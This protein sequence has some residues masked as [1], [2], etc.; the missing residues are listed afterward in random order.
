MPIAV[1]Q[2]RAIF[3]YIDPGLSTRSP[4]HC[5]GQDDRRQWGKLRQSGQRVE[6]VAV[7]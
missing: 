1:K 6:V 3:A 2:K 7:A 5:W 4:L